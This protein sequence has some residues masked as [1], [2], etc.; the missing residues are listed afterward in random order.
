MEDK[1]YESQMQMVKILLANTSS[2]LKISEII[3][4]HSNTDILKETKNI[5]ANF[6]YENN[7]WNEYSIY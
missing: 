3:C 4:K 6:V 2:A 1:I 7:D 5:I